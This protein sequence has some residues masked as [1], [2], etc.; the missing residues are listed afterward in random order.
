MLLGGDVLVPYVRYGLGQCT[1]PCCDPSCPPSLFPSFPLS[2]Q[3]EGGPHY[4]DMDE[5][6]MYESLQLQYEELYQFL[7]E[8]SRKSK[9]SSHFFGVCTLRARGWGETG[10]GRVEGLTIE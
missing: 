3:E 2:L 4:P 9:V 10:N 6:H 7:K 5:A 1:E 8:N